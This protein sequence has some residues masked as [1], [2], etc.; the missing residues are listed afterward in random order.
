MRKI[1]ILTGR[2]LPG[3]KDG[4]P[5]RTI[6]N[7]TD[8]LGDEYDFYIVCLD[9]DHGDTAPYKNIRYDV[10][11]LVGKARVRYVKAGGFSFSF[12]RKLAADVD[13][14]YLC[15]FFDDYG[16][17][18]LLLNR[19]NMLHGKPVAVASMGTFSEGALSQKALKKRIF[20]GCCKALGLF[21]N[22]KWSV[23]SE[24]ELGDVKRNIGKDA[25]CMIAEDL[26]RSNVPGRRQREYREY[27]DVVFLSRISPM[28]NLSG[29]IKC[30]KNLQ[31]N[32]R[33]TIYGPK[34]DGV[35][36]S[37]CLKEL[38]NL[39][40]NI[41]WSYKGDVLSEEVQEKLQQHEIFLFPTKGENYGHVIFEAL[42]VGCIPVIS[43]QTPW[44]RLISE[45]KAGYILQLT[46][47]MKEFTQVLERFSKMTKEEKK[48]ISEHAIKI[49][50][51]K[52]EQSKKDTGY[53]K[54][55]G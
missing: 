14:I 15:G 30:L 8:A 35:Y 24:L 50:V 28:K 46:E 19:L 48:E 3:H 18:I 31:A 11:N 2:Y 38:D 44:S 41:C 52:V 23:T 33:F 40:S 36:W 34:E 6:V 13:L 17:K 5:L 51:E 49:A 54:I 37:S 21:R 39:P 10:W 43:D 27:L 47:D 9:R 26:P 20:I 32:V 29:A 22:M 4:G 25:E 45:R 12:L 16:Y 1:L 53:R 42:S 55:F 7:L